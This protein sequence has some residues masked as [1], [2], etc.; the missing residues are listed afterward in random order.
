MHPV[1][2]SAPFFAASSPPAAP[3]AGA[4][5]RSQ[6]LAAIFEVL[7]VYIVGQLVGFIIGKLLG[8]PLQNP[9]SA[10]EPGATPAQL[11]DIT[12]QLF[13]ILMLQYSGW[14]GV[15]FAVGWWHRRRTPRQYGVTLA[16]RPLL[17]HLLAGVVLFVVADLPTKAL[18]L[19]NSLVPLG[20]QAAWRETLLAM[21]WGTWEFWLLS[22]VGSYGL[23]PI[24]EELFYRGYCQSRLEEDLGAPGAILAVAALFSLSH[25]QY[26]I[27]NV[28]NVTMLLTSFF[29]AVVWGYLFYRTRSLLPSIVAHALVNIP[30]R[31]AAE[32]LLLGGMILVG[33]VARQEIAAYLREGIALLRT[34]S[35]RVRLVAITLAFGLFAVGSVVLGD[36]VLLLALALFVAALV[37][38]WRERRATARLTASALAA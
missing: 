25:S 28:F 24:L 19:V 26:H 21:D 16:G 20:E 3:P 22:A 35:G 32:W 30:M 29:G 1:S 14:L 9:L 6:Q 2:S 13:A 27:L 37:L 11:L 23:I 36:L 8:V 31:G 15:A 33:I 12:R 38:E 4:R 7:G 18:S 5:S 10:L 34:A 17:W